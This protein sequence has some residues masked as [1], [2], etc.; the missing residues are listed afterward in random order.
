MHT[1]IKSS[2]CFQAARQ[3]VYPNTS[4]SNQQCH[5]RLATLFPELGGK[6]LTALRREELASCCTRLHLDS[7][8]NRHALLSRLSNAI[9]SGAHTLPATTAPPTSS[10][11]SS[12][13]TALPAAQTLPAATSSLLPPNIGLLP[14]APITNNQTDNQISASSTLP[15]S[16]SGLTPSWLHTVAQQAAQSAIAQALALQPSVVPQAPSPSTLQPTPTVQLSQA[17]VPP[18]LPHQT[19]AP[20]THT[21]NPPHPGGAAAGPSSA[22]PSTFPPS[23]SQAPPIPPTLP[24]GASASLAGFNLPGELSGMLTHTVISKILTL[25]YFD[26]SALLPANLAIAR[27]PQPIRVQLGGD[28][29]QQLVLSRH[30]MTKKTIV[31]IHDWAIVFSMYATVLTT[32]NPARG[33]DLFEYMRLILQAEKEYQGDAWRR[34]DT[35]FRTCAANRH[36]LHWAEPDSTLWNRAFSGMCRSTSYCSVCLDSTH[37]TTECPLYSQGP[38]TRR[39]TTP[40][41]PSQPNGTDLRPTCSQAC[42]NWNRGKCWFADCRRAHVCAT[43]GCGGDHRFSEC[44]KRRLSPRKTSHNSN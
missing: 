43:Q 31:T 24:T 11:A 38:A 15:T 30:P 1:V 20:A 6:R 32:A 23:A 29:T 19:A 18:T 40:A 7:S 35:A 2:W 9:K 26:L 22:Q 13:A 41:G 28:E 39:S 12:V 10:S 5:S 27:D 21:S 44:P 37:T 42:L 16:G 36:L 8:G 34:Y 14:P 17:P 33:P 4:M 3:T 25:Q